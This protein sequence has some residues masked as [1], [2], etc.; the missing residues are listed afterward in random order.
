MPTCTP[1]PTRSTWS[2][3][4]RRRHD[5][6]TARKRSLNMR[7]C[8][9]VIDDSKVVFVPEFQFAGEQV[10]GSTG[11]QY[12]RNR[13]Y[14]METGRFISRDPLSA[15]PGW[16]EH[17]YMYASANPVNLV[18]PLG[19]VRSIGHLAGNAFPHCSSALPRAIAL[20]DEWADATRHTINGSSPRVGG[21]Q[22]RRRDLLLVLSVDRARSNLYI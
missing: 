19:L 17:P 4:F 14:D 2:T 8:R 18:D 22:V 21:P 1:A 7:I 5:G 12:L 3:R 11:L 10:D 6:A 15:M 16:V 13:Y 20:P 9:K